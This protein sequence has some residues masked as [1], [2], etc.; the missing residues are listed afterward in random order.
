MDELLQHFI[1]WEQTRTHSSWTLHYTEKGFYFLDRHNRKQQERYIDDSLSK[2]LSDR[3]NRT[4]LVV[5][6][7][8]QSGS[9]NKYYVIT[10]N[11]G[12]L[13]GVTFYK[14]RN[15]TI[16]YYNRFFLDD[17]MTDSEQKERKKFPFFPLFDA[18]KHEI[19]QLPE[20]RIAAVTGSLTF[21]SI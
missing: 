4:V 11:K 3:L 5:N 18:L 9:D 16:R 10:E 2:A 8:D 1:E 21:K 14:S 17:A 7:K 20:Y 12:L 19:E 15:F 6:V 13:G